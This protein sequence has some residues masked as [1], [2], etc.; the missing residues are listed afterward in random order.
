MTVPVDRPD[1]PRP[2]AEHLAALRDEL[3][4]PD[5]ADVTGLADGWSAVVGPDLAGHCRPGT[6][7]GDVL[8][9]VVDTP[10]VAT[11]LRYLEG[12]ILEY[13]NGRLGGREVRRVR[14]RGALEGDG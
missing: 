3:G 4:L 8:V 12:A 11:P 9:V 13:V 6:V 14:V 7:H 5:A 1:E 10:A 2:L